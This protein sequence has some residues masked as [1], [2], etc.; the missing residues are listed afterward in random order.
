MFGHKPSWGLIPS[1]GYIDEPRSCD[2]IGGVESDIN[3]FGPIAR[4]VDDLALLVDV[5]ARP[6][7]RSAV[8]IADLAGRTAC[9]GVDRRTGAYR[10]QRNGRHAARARS[11]TWKLL[12]RRSIAT[13]APSSMWQRR[14]GMG[15]RLIDE[16]TTV[17]AADDLPGAL[18]HR[19]W[20]R[21]APRAQSLAA[22]SGSSS[23]RTS[24][25]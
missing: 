24:T 1:F 25:C 23:S 15:A 2:G 11:T 18:S 9:C 14:G 7:A 16:A 21:D 5:M 20:L 17:H 19:Q 8:A 13:P 6:I 4:G 12:A 10:R 22:R 3:V